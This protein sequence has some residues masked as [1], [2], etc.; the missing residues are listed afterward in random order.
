MKYNKYKVTFSNFYY[1]VNFF[2]K[3]WVRIPVIGNFR[4]EKYYSR[5]MVGCK[6]K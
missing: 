4:A 5:L 3:I 1:A 2:G 6:L